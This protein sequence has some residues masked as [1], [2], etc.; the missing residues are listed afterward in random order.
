MS[1]FIAGIFK[2]TGLSTATRITEAT[3]VREPTGNMTVDSTGNLIM[4]CIFH[5]YDVEAAAWTS[6]PCILI[7]DGTTLKQIEG[8]YSNQSIRGAL[9]AIGT[10]I[11]Y[12]Y[13]VADSENLWYPTI[14][15]ASSLS[16]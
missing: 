16:P 4:M 12:V 15:R 2:V 1:N 7:W 8:D 13:G 10:T 5:D 3:I 6:S 14:L 9:L 11:Y